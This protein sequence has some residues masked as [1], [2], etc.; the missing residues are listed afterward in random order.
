VA[1]AR[2]WGRALA[3]LMLLGLA[4]FL[5]DPAAWRG[6]ANAELVLATL[7][8]L[9]SLLAWALLGQSLAHPAP[10]P[11][12]LRRA[13]SRPVGW[14]A[15]RP[16]LAGWLAGA[17]VLFYFGYFTA[18]TFANHATL[19]TSGFDLGIEDNL[20]W[21]AA[22]RS[23]PLFFNTPGGGDMTAAGSHMTWFSYLLAQP[24]RLWPE[25]RF[26]LAFQSL[27]LALGG[28]PLFL[29]A[30]DRL[31][32][33][34]AALL[35]WLYVLYPPLHGANLYDFHYQPLSIPTL[36]AFALCLDRGRTGWA[37]LFAALTLSFREDLGLLLATVCLW[38]AL[39]GRRP[40][41]AL[42]LAALSAVHFVGL[43]LVWM[44]RY[45]GGGESFIHQ[46]AGLLA[47]G[48]GGFAG[49]LDTVL[50]NPAYTW[51]WVLEPGK[52]LYLLQVLGPLLLVPLLRPSNW[53]LFLPGF[54]FTL[55]STNYP[56]LRMISFQYSAY[57][58][59]FVF[60]GL[61]FALERLAASGG[62]R[63]PAVLPA[64]ALATV[65]HSR[66]FGA[67]LQQD[68]VHGS[69]H[70]D[71]HLAV[72]EADRTRLAD[73]EALIAQI[74]PEAPVAAAELVVP[75][76]TNRPE[77]YTLRV[78]LYDS[79]YLIATVPVR[80][81][82]LP[83]LRQALSPGAP[84]GVVEVRGVFVLARKGHPQALNPEAQRLLG[85]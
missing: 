25:A 64:L 74:P 79:E 58:V 9:T 7:I 49:V 16:G 65:L 82:E 12:R 72:S 8:G 54:F 83:V 81:D 14:L 59:P 62:P 22:F 37:L 48:A 4:P 1:L 36:L 42:G 18:F 66:H 75:H 76:V 32:P 51:G 80:G 2:R 60:L 41:L 11:E 17:G 21:N 23:R 40:L 28:V 67:V 19:H 61:V 5:A 39:T 70:Q 31:G 13:W 50:T 29:L 38:G 33:W 35:V 77:A 73:L 10:W 3:P 52:P 63:W 69:F 44:P 68:H 30:R 84:F 45:H 57:W 24:Y 85:Y 26:L 56:A 47:E 71:M 27:M 55:L 43:K 78:G 46:Y 15:A 34:V 6:F 20:L 53:L